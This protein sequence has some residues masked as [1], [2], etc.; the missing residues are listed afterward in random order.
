MTILLRS[1]DFERILAHCKEVEPNEACGIL[2]GKIRD[3]D[4]M[5]EKKV[6]Y[7]VG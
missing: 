5:I 4:G 7:F 2:A 1:T 3:I 6:I